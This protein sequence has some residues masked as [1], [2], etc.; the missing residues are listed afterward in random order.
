MHDSD[1]QLLIDK[2]IRYTDNF[3]LTILDDEWFYK[4]ETR[5]WEPSSDHHNRE[6][7]D[8][9]WKKAMEKI[10]YYKRKSPDGGIFHIPMK[11][12]LQYLLS[13]R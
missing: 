6:K 13:T 4:V 10:F 12:P 3:I 5:K 9:Q 1:G 7:S 8:D 11:D 2:F